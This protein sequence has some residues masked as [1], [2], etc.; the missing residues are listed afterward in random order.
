MREH[1][2]LGDARGAAGVLQ[3]GDVP[4]FDLDLGE[5]VPLPQAERVGKPDR[6]RNIVIGH[7]LLHVAQHEVDDRPLG[8]SKQ[9]AQA[10]GDHLLHL[11]AGKRV[12]DRAAEV[13]DHQDRNRARV[14]EL[15]LQLPRGVHRVHVH[16]GQPRAQDAERGDRVLQA[17]GHHDR[18]AIAFLQPEFA[19]QVGRQLGAGAVDLPIAEGLAEVAEGGIVAVAVDRAL[20]DL[21]HR[22]ILVRVDFGRNASGVARQPGACVVHALISLFLSAATYRGAVFRADWSIGS[23]GW[24]GVLRPLPSGRVVS[25]RQVQRTGRWTR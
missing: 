7:H 23:R 2:A 21:R 24:Q 16:H 19:Q 22:G 15:V 10:G 11:G 3:E 1:G 17:V 14:D 4:G 8:K 13:V 12:L 9:V 25:C 20:Q 18:D 6:A 5:A